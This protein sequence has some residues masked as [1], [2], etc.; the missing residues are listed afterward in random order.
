MSQRHGNRSGKYPVA[1]FRYLTVAINI[2][3]GGKTALITGATRGIGKAISEKFIEAGATVYLTGTNE[4]DINQYTYA[5]KNSNVHWLHADFSTRKGIDA[6]I[7]KLKCINRIDICIN[8]AGINIIK[9]YEDCSKDEY[10]RLMS[11]NLTAP[12]ILTQYLMIGM[13][14]RSFGRVV[15]IASI[16]SQITKP[17]RTLYSSSKTGLLGFTRATAVEHAPWNILVN[18]VSPGFTS[19]ELTRQSLSED[20]MKMLSTQIPL[21]RFAV[22]DEIAMTVLFLCSDL[23]NYITGQNITIDGGYTLV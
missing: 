5:N 11:V 12:F 14:E 22:P 15:N 4:A 9:P 20:E 8:N 17:E 10:D 16:W 3:L 6:F 13:K 19:T 21:Q 1:G 7:D 23:N 2:D 18:A